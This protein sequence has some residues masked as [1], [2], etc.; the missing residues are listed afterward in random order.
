MGLVPL[1]DS[2]RRAT[3][4]D[5]V[6]PAAIVAALA[7]GGFLRFWHLNGLGYNSDEAV[8]AGQGASIAGVP[9]LQHFFPIFRRASAAL[10]GDLVDSVLARRR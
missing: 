3:I 9:E 10:P 6:I 7:V 2:L 8:Y 1:R 4:S 5:A